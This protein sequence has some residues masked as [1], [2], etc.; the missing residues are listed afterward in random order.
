MKIAAVNGSPKGHKSNSNEIISILKK[1]ISADAEWQIVSQIRDFVRMDDPDFSD[2]LYRS[3]ILI[4]AFPLYVDSLPASLMKFLEKYRKGC[5]TGGS[6][7]LAA[8]KKQRVF[9]VAN[10]GFHEGLQNGSALEMIGH[11]CNSAGLSWCGG[12]GIGTGEMILGIKNVPPEAG[13]RKPVTEALRKIADAIEKKDGML[14]E[15]I[16]TQHKIPWLLYK[17]AGEFGWRQ[18]IKKN[19]LSR[20]EINAKPLLEKPVV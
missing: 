16:Y 18:Q 17:I 9:A 6:T 2:P 1:M 4:I 19:R 14:A 11:F 12:A 15:N 13:I 7:D 3:D 10:C 20:K 5:I 8:G